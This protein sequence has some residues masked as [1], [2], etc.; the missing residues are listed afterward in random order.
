MTLNQGNWNNDKVVTNCVGITGTET[1]AFGYNLAQL[2]VTKRVG[3]AAALTTTEVVT[4]MVDIPSVPNVFIIAG[5]GSMFGVRDTTNAGVNHEM[6]IPGYGAYTTA[7]VF[8]KETNYFYAATI[9]SDVL[10]MEYVNNT[11]LAH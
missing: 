6:F 3:G 9:G 1:F 4:A 8:I 11:E 10:R 5:E 2:K 7:M